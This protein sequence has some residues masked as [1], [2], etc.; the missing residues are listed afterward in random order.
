MDKTVNSLFRFNE[1][2]IRSSRIFRLLAGPLLG[3]CVGLLGG[4][5]GVL[6]GALLG[7]LIQQLLGQF[8]ID[9]EIM[10]Y[11]ENP[12]RS[13]FDEGTPGLAA[14][15]AL[16]T[17]LIN[18]TQTAGAPGRKI[19]HGD[20]LIS[21]RVIHSAISV[22]PGLG[23]RELLLMET[24]CRLALNL[25]DRL[26]PDLLAES[27]A[28]RRAALGDL[29]LLGGELESLALGDKAMQ[30]AICIR[31][32]LDPGYIAQGKGANTRQDR[33]QFPGKRDP[34]RILGLEPGASQK[35][36]KSCFRKLAVLFH[37]D[38]LQSLD[39]KHQQNAAKTF[40]LIKDAYREL[41]RIPRREH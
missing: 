29:P 5:T 21:R 2:K 19:P 25:A 30:E 32:I 31:S 35:E 41:V 1:K 11:F 28:S 22:F 3:G 16:G 4:I 26:N 10:R 37:P 36:I 6:I 14:F 39:E 8:S 33:R 12:G 15:C 27:L 23:S 17:I 9:K 18:Q 38:A 24:F 7:C 40:I 20:A 34:W 13:T